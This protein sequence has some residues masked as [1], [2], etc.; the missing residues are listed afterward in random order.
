MLFFCIHNIYVE[1][2]RRIFRKERS[3]LRFRL[4]YAHIFGNLWLRIGWH[5]HSKTRRNL[6]VE[7]KSYDNVG[8]FV[9]QN[10]NRSHC[11]H[12]KFLD[13][14]I[15]SRCVHRQ[16][17]LRGAGGDVIKQKRCLMLITLNETL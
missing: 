2:F 14:I 8:F 5:C 11:F 13:I 16:A 9:P 10:D 3:P 15:P 1:L 12:Q 7:C 4:V 17:C 6:L